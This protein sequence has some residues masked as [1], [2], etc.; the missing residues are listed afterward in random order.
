VPL[1]V[2]LRDASGRVL[3][4]T[5]GAEL[6]RVMPPTDDPDFP[7]LGHVDPYGDTVFNPLQMRKVLPEIRLLKRLA[8]NPGPV[9][10]ELETLAEQCEEGV[11]IFLVFVGD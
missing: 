7:M 8:P 3:G 9:L 6:D 2:E 5:G 1:T 11:H 10:D 4:R